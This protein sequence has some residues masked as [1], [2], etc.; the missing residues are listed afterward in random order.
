MT[1]KKFAIFNASISSAKLQRN[2]VINLNQT[3]QA[4]TKGVKEL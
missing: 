3:C 2:G 4:W 1:I